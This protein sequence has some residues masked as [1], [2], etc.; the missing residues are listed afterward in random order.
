MLRSQSVIAGIGNAYSD[1]ILHAARISPF[2][3]AKSLDRETVRVLYDAIHSVLGAAV[4]DAMG[5]A[6]GDL[7]DAKRSAMRVH[8]R[9]RAAVPGL[10]GHRPGSVL[11]RHCPAVLPHL[12]D[13]RQD[14]GRPP[15]LPVPQIARFRK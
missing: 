13:Q 15:D 11:R 3:I 7:K 2:A 9:D 12:P 1:E 8:G 14:P 5:K 4:Q 6:P 10:R